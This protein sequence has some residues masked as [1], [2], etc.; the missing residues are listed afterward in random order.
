MNT[1]DVKTRWPELAVSG[2]LLI[3]GGMVVADSLRVGIGWAWLPAAR[4]VR[5]EKD[6][7]DFVLPLISRS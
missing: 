5:V 3:L 6:I 7:S 2:C 4:S 1:Q